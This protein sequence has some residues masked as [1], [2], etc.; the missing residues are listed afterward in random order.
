MDGRHGLGEP[1]LGEVGCRSGL[2]R[3]LTGLPGRGHTEARTSLPPTPQ[4]ARSPAAATA[5]RGAAR[6]NT[7]LGRVEGAQQ[8][9]K[10]QVQEQRKTVFDRHKMLS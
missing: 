10:L 6:A 9:W 1:L 4:D 3:A 7:V 8:R 5:P 2:L